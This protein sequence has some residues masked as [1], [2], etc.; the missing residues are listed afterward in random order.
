MREGIPHNLPSHGVGGSLQISPPVYGRGHTQTPLPRSGRGLRGGQKTTILLFP[1]RS[2]LSAPSLI[3]PHAALRR[4]GGVCRECLNTLQI[5]I[6][7]EFTYQ[8]PFLFAGGD[9]P[10]P[11]LPRSGRGLRG[12]QKSTLLLFPVRSALSAPSLI[13]P[14]E[15]GE[16]FVEGA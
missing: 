1:V 13:L 10:Q 4:R 2:T 15:A 11:P 12:G 16:G 7:I 9:S 5:S 8:S 6:W 3:L 14:R